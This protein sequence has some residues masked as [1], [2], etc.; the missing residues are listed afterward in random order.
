MATILPPTLERSTSLER[1]LTGG[2]VRYRVLL[3]FVPLSRR[4]SSRLRTHERLRDAPRKRDAPP[5]SL[6][7][8]PF[9]LGTI[10]SW[11]QSRTLHILSCYRINVLEFL[12]QSFHSSPSYFLVTQKNCRF[13]FAF[14]DWT[15][16]TT[17]ELYF[18]SYYLGFCGFLLSF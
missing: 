10:L 1:I 17:L 16:S 9:S 6:H 4:L 8:S 5:I 7:L 12:L 14:I 3:R 13:K 15:F 11:Y 2:L 18:N